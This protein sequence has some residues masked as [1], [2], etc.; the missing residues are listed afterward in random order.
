M[1]VGGDRPGTM[2]VRPVFIRPRG[3]AVADRSVT[4][5]GVLIAVAILVAAGAVLGIGGGL[6]GGSLL[7]GIK[8]SAP[9]PPAPRASAGPTVTPTPSA[10]SSSAAAAATTAA[11]TPTPQTLTAQADKTSAKPG[12]RITITGTY[13]GAPAGT[14]LQVQ[15]KIG[16]GDWKDFPA[17]TR[18]DSSGGYDVW[19]RTS[20][21]GS[22]QIRVADPSA[23]VASDPISITIG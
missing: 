9:P 3:V 21:K 8:A 14:S 18:T 17:R 20:V 16:D 11:P 15:R 6:L 19:M 5:R 23:G 22:Q 2:G 13:A 10:H 12:E 7:G 1:M 4:G